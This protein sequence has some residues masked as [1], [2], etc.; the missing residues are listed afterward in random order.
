MAKAYVELHCHSAYSFQEGASWPHELLLRAKELGYPAL[1]LTDH[2]NLTIALDFAQTAKSLGVHP[3]TGA[4]ITLLGGHHLTLLAA[5]AKGYAN[6]CKLLSYA[7]VKGGDRRAPAVDPAWFGEHGQGLIVL[8]GCPRGRVPALA[9]EGKMGEA[10]AALRQYLDWFGSE[11]VFME[12]NQNLAQG[13][14]QRNRRLYSLAKHLG[15]PVVATNNVHYHLPE[16]YRLHDAL[17]AVK[18]LK[19]LAESHRE[20]RANNEFYLKSAEEMAL[21][22]GGAEEA[23]ANT[24]RIAERCAF[25]VTSDM[26]YQ[27]PAYPVPDGSSE[28]SYLRHICEEA[29]WRKYGHITERVQ[30]RLDQE[31]QRIGKHGLAGF[32]LLYYEVIQLAREV[33]IELG[34]GDAETPL[35]DDPPGRGRGS[36]VAM[37]TGYLVG[38]SHID[39]LEYDLGLDRFLPEDLASVPD[40]D[41]DFPRD[42]RE[43]LILRIH[44]RYGWEHAA[45]VGAVT[46]YQAR[47]V[48]R[49][50]GKALTLPPDL[51]DRLAKRID[52][53]DGRHL[54]EEMEGL[55]EFKHLT[56]APGWR[57]LLELAPQMA[58]LPR[59]LQQ[60]SGGMVIATKP[61]IEVV[62]IMRGA[63]EGRYVMQW[64][65][66]AVDQAGM[67]KI[68]FLALG[69]LSQMQEAVHLIE[70]RTGKA[71]DLSRIDF[72]DAAVYDMLAEADTIGIFQVE[73]AAQQQTL[74]RLRPRNLMDMAYEVACVRPGVGAVDGVTHFIHRR[75]GIEPITYEH[76]LEKPA[77]ERTLGVILYQDQVME[78]AM[79]VAGMS[80][81]NGDLLRR[82]FAKKNN[83]AL[84]LHY[85]ERFRDGAAQR[86]VPEATALR[87]FGKINGGYQFPEAHAVAFG[88][89]AYQ[90][91]WLKHYHPLEFYVGLLNAQPMGFWGEDTIRGDA[92]R[93]GILFLHPQI[94]RSEAKALIEGETIRLG[95]HAVKNIGPETARVVLEERQR[96]GPYGS[97]ADFM[98]RTKLQRE[99]LESLAMAGALDGFGTERRGVLWEIG[100]R[101]QPIGKQAVL[102]MPTKQDMVDLPR[103]TRWER[104]AAE[105]RLMGLSPDGHLFEELRQELGPRF[106]TSERLASLEEGA[107]VLV[108]GM[109]VRLQ[110]PAAQAYFVTLEDEEGL[111]PLVL[112]E[113]MY[114]QYRST[115][116]ETFVLAAGRVSRKEGTVNIIVERLGTLRDFRRKQGREPAGAG[117][118]TMQQPRPYFR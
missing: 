30:E 59:G 6:L 94:N 48:I 117:T 37:L 9:A 2:D 99:E 53:G 49:A 54:R 16:R 43:R 109:V 51:V 65:K 68:D 75:Q 55:P 4:E 82:A 81:R 77:L 61:L 111:I 112:W 13:D 76:P 92:A 105:Y 39:P 50:L 47:G 41:L 62:P 84:L 96:G 44:E 25:D 60:H 90:M 26:G 78:L 74:P 5:T 38:L 29:A 70:G 35:E 88:I 63:I 20:R 116:R 108:G 52:H 97:L 107:F 11:N 45:L 89:T 72:T 64:D 83:E 58:D 21:L 33:M 36:S 101:Y 14:R 91:A 100:L 95:L 24:L 18:H 115:L 8:T 42:I 114:E 28:L 69:T 56:N 98:S 19:S 46:T 31:F 15:V 106:V 66:D 102:S 85:W 103:Q 12:L 3:I 34:H 93:H 118:E 104:L 71:L 110:H 23:L 27:F 40:I 7:H 17:V 1:A 80:A 86:G 87:I 73:S 79:H 67:L 22:F 10:E 32:F 57:T 113:G